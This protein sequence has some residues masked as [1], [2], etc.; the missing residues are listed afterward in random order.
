M[1]KHCNREKSFRHGGVKLQSFTLI[2][3]LVV[4]AI[5][6]IL[7][8]ILLPALQ[9]ARER[10]L[11]ASCQSNLKQLGNT[12]AQYADSFD[13]WIP[14]SH[15]GSGFWW[16]I[17]SWYPASKISS[18]GTPGINH[19][20]REERRRIAPIFWC[21]VRKTNP[22]NPTA[23]KET[24]YLTP[25]WGS[26]YQ[27]IPKLT[28]AHNPAQK[29]MLLESGYDGGGLAVTLPRY[30]NHVFH[31]NNQMNVLHLDGHVEPRTLEIPYVQPSTGTKDQGYFHYHWKPVCNTPVKHGKCK[32]TICET[33]P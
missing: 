14:R 22:R 16:A 32:G 26:H 4:I 27:G 24:Y 29:F 12:F 33:T 10:S 5:I 17:R 13:G 2:E 31:H 18:S 11:G 9:A 21:P 15:G 7:A 25:S 1:I 30:S 23:H 20:S 8:A 28:R 3:L 6:A 19:T